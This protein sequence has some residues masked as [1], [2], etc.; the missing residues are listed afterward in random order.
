[1]K[2]AR[3]G[4]GMVKGLKEKLA[5]HRKEFHV[6]DGSLRPRGQGGEGR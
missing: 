1:M 3:G 5:R 4:V 6:R 2:C